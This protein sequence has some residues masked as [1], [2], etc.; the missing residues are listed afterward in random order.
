MEW[1]ESCSDIK[2]D[3]LASIQQIEK[4]KQNIEDQAKLD[5]EAEKLRKES[6]KNI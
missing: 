3:K 4:T 6:A 5:A 2:N 1:K